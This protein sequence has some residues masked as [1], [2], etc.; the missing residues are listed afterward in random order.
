MADA[1]PAPEAVIA[2]PPE[3][4][5]DPSEVVRYFL[6]AD[7]S[8]EKAARVSS[9]RREDPLTCHCHEAMPLPARGIGGG[10]QTLR[11]RQKAVEVDGTTWTLVGVSTVWHGTGACG[12]R[13]GHRDR[14]SRAR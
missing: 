4:P 3:I 10:V 13:G 8:L 11:G 14:P 1:E 9:A 6:V 5:E 7:P 12:G 2:P